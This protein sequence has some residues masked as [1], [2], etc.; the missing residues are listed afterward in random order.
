MGG[1]DELLLCMMGRSDGGEGR[2]GN[3]SAV[4]LRGGHIVFV[5]A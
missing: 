4:R 5:I 2:M 1:S 3:H